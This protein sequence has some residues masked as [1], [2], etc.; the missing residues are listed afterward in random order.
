MNLQ[1]EKRSQDAGREL[2]PVAS[3]EG[4]LQ[5]RE[6]HREHFVG[7]QLR[8]RQISPPQRRNFLSLKRS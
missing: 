3:G 8:R 1:G 4:R 6:P 7:F 2:L 5:S